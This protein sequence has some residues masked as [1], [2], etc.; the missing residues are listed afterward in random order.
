MYISPQPSVRQR[1]HHRYTGQL[2]I[3]SRKAGCVS[4]DDFLAFWD[5][6]IFVGNLG[7]RRWWS[8]SV[9]LPTQ[10]SH[11][12]FS[13][14]TIPRVK[15]GRP[16]WLLGQGSAKKHSDQ[17]GLLSVGVFLLL[18]KKEVGHWAMKKTKIVFLL[19]F[20]FGSLNP[21]L[22]FFWSKQH[23]RQNSV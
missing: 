18:R 13:S 16:A 17:P 6:W 12:S 21:F 1:T 2:L 3:E 14:I 4:T 22:G 11:S 15:S 19:L 7:V 20:W 8:F 5:V 10:Q 23:T 9:N